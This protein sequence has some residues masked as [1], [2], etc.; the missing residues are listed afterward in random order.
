[1][2]GMLSSTKHANIAAIC[3]ALPLLSACSGPARAP[4]DTVRVSVVEDDTRSEDGTRCA[5]DLND[6]PLDIVL[7]LQASSGDERTATDMAN[8][9]L[10]WRDGPPAFPI[11]VQASLPSDSGYQ[12]AVTDRAV[13]TDAAG[14]PP[15]FV[16]IKPEDAD[17]CGVFRSLARF[18]D[19][20][21]KSR[22]E[23]EAALFG[24]RA[25]L[26]LIGLAVAAFGLVGLVKRDWAWDWHVNAM[27]FRGITNLERTDN[28]EVSNALSGTIA[29]AIGLMCIGVAVSLQ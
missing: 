5:F 29:I 1:M 8:N 18:D 16:L 6:R 23:S 15:T 12:F 9:S 21:T 14:L 7:N 2:V 19:E 24:L 4:S 11:T 20:L 27:S 28:W 26:G 22:R 13:I 10:A 17:V 3:L 25:V